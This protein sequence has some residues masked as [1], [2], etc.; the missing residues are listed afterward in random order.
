MQT[1]CIAIGY[2]IEPQYL[3]RW[4]PLIMAALSICWQPNFKPVRPD[5]EVFSHKSITSILHGTY[6]ISSISD[7]L[8]AW[9]C[10]ELSSI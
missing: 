9:Q 8:L 10:T 4:L 2:C 6:P 5:T 1:H 3:A 7:H